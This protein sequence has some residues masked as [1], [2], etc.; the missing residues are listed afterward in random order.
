MVELNPPRPYLTSR[1][2]HKAALPGCQKPPSGRLTSPRGCAMLKLE[3]QATET[4]AMLFFF[5]P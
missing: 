5:A 3:M 2:E 4:M 1:A